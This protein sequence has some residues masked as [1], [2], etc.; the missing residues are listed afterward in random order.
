[1]AFN[2]TVHRHEAGPWTGVVDLEHAAVL[3]ALGSFGS[4]VTS[5]YI[6]MEQNIRTTHLMRQGSAHMDTQSN[7]DPG[8]CM[9]LRN[10]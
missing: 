3:P 10:T 2:G 1:M 9:R 7:L 4:A 6:K 8:T 5:R